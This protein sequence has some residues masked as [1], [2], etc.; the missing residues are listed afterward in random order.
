M[1]K[2]RAHGDGGID[3]RGENSWRLRYREG[4]KRY[5]KTFHGT[6]S[7]ARKELARLTTA[8][9]SGQHVAP[10]KI[11]LADWIE[12]WIEAGAPGRRK[13]RVG[14]RA[15]ERYAELLRCHVVPALGARPLQQIKPTEIDKLYA[16]IERRRSAKAA[17]YVHV[18]LGAC[19]GTAARKGLLANNPVEKADAPSAGE[20]DHGMVLDESELTALVQGFR[21]T[22]LYPIVAVAAFT[23]ARRNEILA[24][25]W[26]DL[27]I[28][29][30]TLTIARALEATKAHGRGIKGPKTVRGFRTIVIDDSLINLLVAEREK[31]R[32]LLAGVPDDT[33][34]DLSLVRLP[35]GALMFP[36]GDGTKL[37]ELR[38]E[39]TVSQT[40][41][42]R[43]RRLG[44]PKLRFHDL[45]GS[46][47]T[48]LLDQGQPVHVVAARLGDDPAVLLRSYAKRTKKADTSAADVIGA[49]SKGVIGHV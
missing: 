43:A 18:V 30:R 26:G 22:A 29:N 19:L 17:H 20:A 13:K 47:S 49:L 42:A 33:T 27:S 23:G 35:D 7:E 8:V 39:R 41:K 2:R 38:N 45:R 24:L 10:A 28:E 48:W 6:E 32:R 3:Q 25:Q 1:A 21:G 37:T 34:V 16:E 15:L 44:L 46:H 9:N 4:G 5:T 11:K 12:Q 40:F 31:H 36:G 14:H